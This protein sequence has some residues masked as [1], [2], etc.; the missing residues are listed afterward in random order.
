MMDE[1]AVESKSR[2]WITL[3]LLLIALLAVTFLARREMAP[4][5]V[6]ISSSGWMG[7]L[8]IV[9]IYALL[10]VTPI[11]SEP[12]TILSSTIYG[13]FYAALAAS[14]G[15]LLSALIEYYIGRQLGSVA[16][17][18][19]RREKLPFGLGKFPVDS[20]VFLIGARNLTAYGAKFVSLVAGMYRVPPWRYIWT[21]FVST[22][23]G[24][25]LVA[26]GGAALLHLLFK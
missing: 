25:I 7:G 11:P 12:L 6:F 8:V 15:N 13:P 1:P 2:A 26:Y 18:E 14:I 24:A 20:P 5:R 16:S 9:V 4:L 23:V 3:L 17:F 10:G 21:T 19:Q 22:L